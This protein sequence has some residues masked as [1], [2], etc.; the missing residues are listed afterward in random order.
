MILR[1]YRL[2]TL[3][4]SVK[5]DACKFIGRSSSTTSSHFLFVRGVGG[6]R[7]GGEHNEGLLDEGGGKCKWVGEGGG[8]RKTVNIF[9]THKKG[10]F[11]ISSISSRLVLN[12]MLALDNTYILKFNNKY[13][14]TA[15]AGPC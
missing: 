11:G 15:D 1:I 6:K 8:E 3:L 4:N 13:E 14:R 5:K 2:F 7:E 10:F 9:S 12:F